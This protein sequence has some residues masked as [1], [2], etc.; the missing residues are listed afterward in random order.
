MQDERELIRRAQECDSQALADIYERYYQGIYSY[1]FYRVGD[2]SLAEDLTSEVFLKALEAI[3]SY[4]FRGIPLSAWLYRIAANLVVDY[5]RRQPKQ[6]NLPL[7]ETKLF[8]NDNPAELLERGLTAGELRKALS[9][10]T[11]EQ[12]QVIILKFVNGLSNAEVAK[13]LGKTEGAVKSLQHRA[14]ASLAR[15]LGELG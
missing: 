5:F 3:E 14:L 8:S 2:D 6:P 4:T 10:L 12:K 11:E 9:K 13:V 1:I 15:H 7:E